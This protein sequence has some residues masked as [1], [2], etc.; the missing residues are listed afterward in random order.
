M[1]SIT[2]SQN[3]TTKATSSPSTRCNTW[4]AIATCSTNAL[5]RACNHAHCEWRPQIVVA[6]GTP[7]QQ[8]CDQQTPTDTYARNHPPLSLVLYTLAMALAIICSMLS[9]MSSVPLAT[10]SAAPVPFSPLA[11]IQ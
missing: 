10:P 11:C 1:H 2:A 8:C 6:T 9:V 3:P 4:P 5:C 7:S